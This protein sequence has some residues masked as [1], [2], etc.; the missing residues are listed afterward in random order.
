MLIVILGL[1][2]DCL[3]VLFNLDLPSCKE[4]LSLLQRV[5]QDLEMVVFLFCC[6]M[7]ILYNVWLVNGNIIN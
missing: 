5:C 1:F 4:I 3:F 6:H 2:Y 7:V